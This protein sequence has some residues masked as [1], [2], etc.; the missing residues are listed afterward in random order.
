[1]FVTRGNA[2]I[3]C[4]RQR[5]FALL[6]LIDVAIEGKSIPRVNV[7]WIVGFANRLVGCGKTLR[8]ALARSEFNLARGVSS[9]H[10]VKT[11]IKVIVAKLRYQRGEVNRVPVTNSCLHWNGGDGSQ[12]H[13]ASGETLNIETQQMPD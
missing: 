5:R 12:F 7:V 13:L 3:L 11:K 2:L 9:E 4:R 8:V 1:M 6:G 10:F